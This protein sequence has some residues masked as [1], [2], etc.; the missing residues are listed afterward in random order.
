MHL[1]IFATVALTL[2]LTKV[3]LATTS[4]TDDF[5]T[6]G[7]Q[8]TTGDTTDSNIYTWQVT[9]RVNAS[10]S[11]SIDGNGAHLAWHSNGHGHANAAEIDLVFEVAEQPM[12]EGVD[13]SFDVVERHDYTDFYV[14][15]I[16]KTEQKIT[17]SSTGNVRFEFT[18]TGINEYRNHSL[19]PSHVY[20][21]ASAGWDSTDTISSFGFVGRHH[22]NSH[23]NISSIDNINFSQVP[24]PSSS[25][26]LV[27]GA[28]ALIMRRRK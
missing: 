21:Y 3:T 14:H 5:S 18:D 6:Y 22:D 16:G 15:V 7:S 28:A 19:T 10:T 4:F 23:N 1:S 26:L 24:E 25:S 12:L 8:L 9:N 20:T 2:S 11:V 13:L 17:F 27:L